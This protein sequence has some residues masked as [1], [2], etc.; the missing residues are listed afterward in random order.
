MCWQETLPLATE[1]PS[2]EVQF[3][4]DVTSSTYPSPRT[5]V[6]R[7]APLSF[8]VTVTED[9]ES[10]NDELI[11]LPQPVMHNVNAMIIQ[12]Y[13]RRVF[14]VIITRLSASPSLL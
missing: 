5:N 3:A 1:S 4:K 8:D 13:A 14:R 7:S 6:K 11:P 9:G 10:I 2:D 12:Q